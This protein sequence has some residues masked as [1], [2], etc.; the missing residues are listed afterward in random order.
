[1]PRNRSP[2][3]SPRSRARC[4][5]LPRARA[6]A[7]RFSWD[8]PRSSGIALNLPFD[9]FLDAVGG[10][11]RHAIASAGNHSFLLT[12][13]CAP[14]FRR[15]AVSGGLMRTWSCSGERLYVG[16]LRAS[17]GLRNKAL[18]LSV[19]GVSFASPISGKLL[20]PCFCA[21]APQLRQALEKRSFST[22]AETMRRR[23]SCAPALAASFSAG[24]RGCLALQR[25]GIA[26]TRCLVMSAAVSTP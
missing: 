1:M 25:A 12:G 16:S 6:G 4:P 10:V 23:A 5:I 22:K 18:E 24:G 14:Q 17:V 8:A 20:R 9:F 7:W 19:P 3:R 2:P 21:A 13:R 15:R 26:S 11:F